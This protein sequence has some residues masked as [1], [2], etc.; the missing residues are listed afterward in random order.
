MNNNIDPGFAVIFD[1]DGTLVDSQPLQY[2]AYK[3]AFEKFGFTIHWD[4]WI[5]YW[6]HQS[7]SSYDWITLKKIDVSGDEIK[8]IKV[9]IYNDLIKNELELKSGALKLVNDL[10]DN[11]VPIAIASTSRLDSIQRISNKFFPHQFLVLQSDVDL[12][13]RKPDP[14]IFNVT[15]QKLML[16]PSRCFVIEDSNSGYQA[17]IAANMK[18]IV[19]PDSTLGENAIPFEKSY[20]LVNKLDD[21]NF[22]LLNKY[23][24]ESA[25]NNI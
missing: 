15:A 21:L 4:E 3:L 25:N 10:Y 14:H 9:T 11:H 23:N 6:V 18:V 13:T 22:N 7:I 20:C 12:G 5:K 19:C 1:L 8:K 2:K 24:L 17:G 16:P